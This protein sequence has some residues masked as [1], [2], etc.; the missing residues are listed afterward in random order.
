VIGDAGAVA[1][2]E[3]PFDLFFSRH[4]VMFFADP[5]QAFRTFRGAASPGAALIFSCFQAWELNLWASELASAAAGKA[6][7]PP[8]QEPGGFAFADPDHV[9]AILRSSGW[10]DPKYESVRY[11]YVAGEGE[12]AAADALSFMTDIGPA[13]R[14]LQSL[15]EEERRDSLDRMQSVIERHLDGTAVT[16]PAAAW[17]WRAT[18]S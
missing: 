10:T 1:A 17:I 15:P 12:N 8:G 3:G 11:R 7:P 2:S 14:I 13:S 9:L 18:A 16:F 6:L 5:V 4:G